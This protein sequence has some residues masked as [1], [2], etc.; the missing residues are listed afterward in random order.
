MVN[1]LSVLSSMANEFR[2]AS[3]RRE[4]GF[5]NMPKM[6]MEQNR[7]NSVNSPKVA[8]KAANSFGPMFRDAQHFKSL[9]FC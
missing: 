8:P 6:A 3:P 4:S 7:K 2:S 1:E 9:H 5:Q